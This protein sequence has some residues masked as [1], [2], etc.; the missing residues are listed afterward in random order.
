[1]SI[2][3]SML[4]AISRLEPSLTKAVMR[5]RPDADRQSVKVAALAGLA[6]AGVAILNVLDPQLSRPTRSAIDSLGEGLRGLVGEEKVRIDHVILEAGVVAQARR[7][8]LGAIWT[9]APTALVLAYNLCGE[10]D[11]KKMLAL[12]N[13]PF[14][15]SN[16]IS[17]VLSERLAGPDRARNIMMETLWLAEALADS[18]V[19]PSTSSPQA[20]SKGI[21]TSTKNTSGQSSTA[22]HSNAI[23]DTWHRQAVLELDNGHFDVNLWHEAMISAH[24][25]KAEART[26]YA[27][28]RASQL[29][30]SPTKQR[31]ATEEFLAAGGK[32][33][34]PPAVAKPLSTAGSAIPAADET[35]EKLAVTGRKIAFATISSLFKGVVITCRQYADGPYWSRVFPVGPVLSELE[36]LDSQ[37]RQYKEIFELSD[38]LKRYSVAILN[39]LGAR[40][41]RPISEAIETELPI[42]T[43]AAMSRSGLE[44]SKIVFV[45]FHSSAIVQP[46][47]PSPEP[48]TQ[49][50]STSSQQL[51][52]AR[53]S[54]T[55][56]VSVDED[57]IYTAI[58]NEL[59]NKTYDKGLWTR[60][61]AECNGDETKTKVMYIKRRAK[62]LVDNEIKKPISSIRQESSHQEQ[63]SNRRALDA[64]KNTS[65]RDS[66]LLDFQDRGWKISHDGIKW[67]FSKGQ[68]SHNA[69]TAEDI[70][71]F[72]LSN[73]RN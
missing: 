55:T 14:G 44:R 21:A 43:S 71:R 57:A 70:K 72:W 7:E 67:T 6:T 65:E 52:P 63:E 33:L 5:E 56:E 60:L 32:V 45:N 40:D 17:A 49:S 58:F 29:R 50:G 9:N 26:L 47:K 15:P 68:L 28:K 19:S 4:A 54:A 1:M 39:K 73:K 48:T 46:A 8:I 30:S 38:A 3:S 11:L 10:A 42:A 31:S 59:E 62:I 41:V 37:A 36:N 64:Q 53:Q 23:N 51:E 16:G 12:K 18:A 35:R 27:E 24:N 2:S 13:G 25:D 22:I 66:I 20:A 61:F 69:W 34:K